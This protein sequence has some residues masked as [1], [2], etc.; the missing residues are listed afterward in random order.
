[1]EFYL[2]QSYVYQSG[3]NDYRYVNLGLLPPSVQRTA[4]DA[5]QNPAA[6]GNLVVLAD[7]RDRFP[8]AFSQTT[9]LTTL[10]APDLT[11]AA[12]GSFPFGA[13]LDMVLNYLNAQVFKT[14]NDL[15][16]EAKK[17]SVEINRRS[18]D[19]ADEVKT[20]AEASA[21]ANLMGGALSGSVSAVAGL[22]TVGVSL[23]GSWDNFVNGRDM[24]AL[25]KDQL[26]TQE[27]EDTMERNIKQMQEVAKTDRADAQQLKSCVDELDSPDG[28]SATSR[29]KLDDTI[30]Q[31]DAQ[32]A[33]INAQRA[34][35]QRAKA[36]ADIRS[37]D[38][39][40]TQAERAA[41]KQEWDDLTANEARVMKDLAD[42]EEPLRRGRDAFAAVE[43]MDADREQLKLDQKRITE[44]RG[45]SAR[46]TAEEQELQ[47]LE[48]GARQR[49]Q[50]QVAQ[51][52]HV[53]K[54][55]DGLNGQAAR[56]DTSVA[57]MQKSVQDEVNSRKTVE[58]ERGKDLDRKIATNEGNSRTASTAGNVFA[59]STGLFKSPF[60]YD[61]ALEDSESRHLDAEGQF[62]D[63]SGT[64]T[65]DFGSNMADKAQGAVRDWKE[66]N[67]KQN[68]VASTIAHNI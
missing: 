40:L 38:L 63:K 45:N 62:N 17:N 6:E 3:Q 56:I 32:L 20:K 35:Y 22:A 39:T 52:A 61:A 36:D 9:G 55:I 14:A 34:S 42:R 1:M 18:L 29:H 21:K 49:V 10:P 30:A 68:E 46:T 13:S 31:K 54:I 67:D 11:Q 8:S 43:R 16:A 2:N 57:A 58:A 60:D 28:L 64:V 25:T 37:K 48:V 50:G 26:S 51:R 65:S 66:L 53:Q 19:I 59:Q 33:D 15:S 24:K 23:K 41:A 27:Y 47:K 12:G 4:F 5:L 7:L 44:L